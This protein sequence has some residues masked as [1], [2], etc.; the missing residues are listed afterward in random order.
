M[1]DSNVSKCGYA[2]T[3]SAV[4]TKIHPDTVVFGILISAGTLVVRVPGSFVDLKDGGQV[5]LRFLYSLLCYVIA[6]QE[7]KGDLR[8]KRSVNKCGYHAVNYT[9]KYKLGIA[10]TMF[11]TPLNPAPFPRGCA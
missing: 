5:G 9:S 2:P 10:K 4:L 3:L 7:G 6:I 11:T 1:I 8:F